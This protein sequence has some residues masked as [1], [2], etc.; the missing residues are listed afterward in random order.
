MTLRSPLGRVQTR[1]PTSALELHTLRQAAWQKQGI[2]MIAVAD[3]ADD[4]LRQAITNE[5]DRLYGRR[6]EVSP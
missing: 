2:A 4:W 1:P 5:A 3:I 6:R